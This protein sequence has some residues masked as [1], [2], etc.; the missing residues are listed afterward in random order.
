MVCYARPASLLAA[1]VAVAWLVFGGPV[2][3]F[4]STAAVLVAVLVATASAAVAAALAFATFMSTR[5]RRAGAGGCVNCRFQCQHAMTN[6]SGGR[7]LWL[8]TTADRREPAGPG[9]AVTGRQAP[10]SV[11]SVPVFLPMPEVPRWPDRPLRRVR[12]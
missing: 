1:I 12:G 5:R 10:V 8:V 4:F 9:Q 11:R 2:S 3:H 7:R 6:D